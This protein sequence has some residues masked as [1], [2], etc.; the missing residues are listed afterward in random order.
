MLLGSALRWL[1]PWLRPYRRGL[2]LMVVGDILS[3][4]AQT[5]TPFVF[6]K[7]IDGPVRSGDHRSLWKYG[8]VLLGLAV[9]QTIFYALR[10]MPTTDAP[11]LEQAL[12][13]ELY[14]RIQRLPALFHDQHGSGQSVS[15][16]LEDVSQVGTFHHLT[17][18]FL[19]SN[20]I[21]IGVTGIMLLIVQPV[22][23]GIVL[24]ALI[25]LGFASTLFQNQFRDAAGR[26][27]ERSGDLATV[28]AE[29]ESAMPLLKSLGGRRFAIIRVVRAAN[30]VRKA[31]IRKVH[32]NSA[33]NAALMAYPLVLLALIVVLGGLAAANG[34][35]TVGAFVA[36]TTFYLRM[37]FPVSYMGNLLSSLQEAVSAIGRIAEFLDAEA[38]ISSPDRPLPLPALGPLSV[39]LD[40]VEFGY[41]TSS[42][43]VLDGVDLYIGPGETLALVGA[44]GSGKTTLADLVVRLAEPTAGSVLVGG[45]NVR[46]LALDD[47]RQSVGMAFEDSTLFSG[48]VKDNL[49][50]ARNGITLDEIAAALS[51]AQADFVFHLTDGLDTLIGEQGT[52]L[53]GGQRQRVAL[54]RALLGRPRVLILDDP[55]S[56][57]DVRTEESVERRLRRAFEGVTLLVVARR[58][59]T[60]MLADRVAV[61]DGGRIVDTGTH[62]E[63]L[64]RSATYRHVL[65]A[66][67]DEVDHGISGVNHE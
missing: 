56:S 38:T 36:F 62:A 63:L 43:A 67:D 27:R 48:T 35:L 25:P 22:I 7:V 53:S 55:T 13:R 10:R 46:D 19:I 50:M 24:G 37:L 20:A 59:A 23:G 66:V 9:V 65:L 18:V 11:R 33:F 31:E 57:L 30:A 60:A 2:V 47:L 54:A 34:S 45:V 40:G 21:T 17:L 44:T 16:I 32:L 52:T 42:P 29:L 14:R 61:L 26:A 5:V 4:V 49:V 41:S 12:R 28:A 3:L 58:P 51:I 6:A 39:R 15:R 64:E 1:W 8:V